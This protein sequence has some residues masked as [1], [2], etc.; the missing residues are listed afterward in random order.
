GR[1]ERAAG[2][3]HRGHV[4]ADD[5]QHEADGNVADQQHGDLTVVAG[6]P[7]QHSGTTASA[8]PAKQS[9]RSRW[10]ADTTTPATQRRP[11]NHDGTNGSRTVRRR[12]T[13]NVEP[14]AYVHAPHETTRP[15]PTQA[16]PWSRITS[17]TA[18]S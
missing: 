8:V 16:T 17:A 10:C 4:D 9:S 1:G 7:G 14:G 2:Q 3:E 5:H 6:P 18:C 12:S 13:V 11:H 15:E